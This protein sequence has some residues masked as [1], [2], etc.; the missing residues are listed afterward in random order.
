MRRCACQPRLH[1]VLC[2]RKQLPHSAAV[3][4]P[5]QI[6]QASPTALGT[7]SH[8]SPGR[9]GGS[10]AVCRQLSEAGGKVQSENPA[11]LEQLGENFSYSCH[12]WHL[13]PSHS[14]RGLLGSTWKKR[15]K[16][17]DPV[18][19]CMEDFCTC[20]TFCSSYQPWKMNWNSES[21][22]S[23]KQSQKWASSPGL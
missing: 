8:V 19:E 13:S 12:C 16:H 10:S 3:S 15:W 20:H 23:Q 7:Q 14:K 1:E 21:L 22:V 18:L 6:T 17:L 2:L 9:R 4:C 11:L 5:F